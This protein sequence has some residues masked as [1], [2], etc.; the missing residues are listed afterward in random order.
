MLEQNL[1]ALGLNEKEVVVYLQVFKLGRATPATVSR[2]TGINRTTIYSVTK[3]LLKKGILAGD[4]GAKTLYLSALPPQNLEALLDVKR[5]QLVEQ[6]SIVAKAIKELQEVPTGAA[7]SVPKIRYIDEAEVN[8]YLDRNTDKWNKSVGEQDKSWWGFQDST[9]VEHFDPWIRNWFTRKSSHE[10]KVQLI[11]NKTEAER[12]VAKRKYGQRAMRFSKQ[13]SAF[14]ATVWA[15]GDYLIMIYT[16]E[17]PFY[18]I[19]IYNPVLADN[20]REMFKQLWNTV[21][22]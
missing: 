21:K 17:H 9:F 6:E 16:R 22:K 18:L 15:A 11:T 3:E 7:A 10:L 12:K 2:L 8:E 14:T 20:M 13:S 19:E 1:K 4:L 5:K